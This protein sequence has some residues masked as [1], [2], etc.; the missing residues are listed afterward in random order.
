MDNSYSRTAMGRSNLLNLCSLLSSL[1]PW[2]GTSST[3]SPII[4]DNDP[5]H[6]LQKA[7]QIV[8]GIC[9]RVVYPFHSFPSSHPSCPGLPLYSPSSPL[10]IYFQTLIIWPF[11]FLKP[12]RLTTSGWLSTFNRLALRPLIISPSSPSSFWNYQAD[13]VWSPINLQLFG[14]S[15][16]TITKLATSGRLSTFNFI[17]FIHSQTANLPDKILPL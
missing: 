12:P 1:P 9:N 16:F 8:A 11:I 3:I 2:F 4:E 15:S 17:V 7:R 6:H 13:D 5:L 10:L 14:P